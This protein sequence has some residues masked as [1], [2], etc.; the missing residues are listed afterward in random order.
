MSIYIQYYHSPVGELILGDHN[1]K[2]CL[3]DWKYRRMRPQ[4]DKRIQSLLDTQYKDAPT[5]ITQEAI[6]QLEAYFKAERTIFDLPLL[7]LGTDFQQKVWECLR[8]IPYGTTISYGDLAKTVGAQNL[9]PTINN[10]PQNLAPTQNITPPHPRAV[11][12]ANGANAIS[13]FIPCH[14]VIG[15]DGALTG[16]AGGLPAKKKLL[17]LEQSKNDPLAG[18]RA[19]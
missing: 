8:N 11:A 7:P 10:T 16:Y 12:S 2:L 18:L 19:G 6:K 9:A 14:R 15:A 17:Q 5:D 13:I 1:G 3:C 4:V